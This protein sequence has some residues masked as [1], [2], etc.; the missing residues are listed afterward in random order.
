MSNS[1]AGRDDDAGFSH[2]IDQW[3]EDRLRS[4]QRS[5]GALVSS[6]PGVDPGLA[7]LSLERLAGGNLPERQAAIAALKD[8]AAAPPT[9]VKTVDRPVP[10]P[11]DYFWGY[12]NDS[13]GS[14]IDHVTRATSPGDRVVYLGAPN[15]F[16]ACADAMP[17]RAHFLL[18]RRDLARLAA[19]SSNREFRRV[20]LLVDDVPRLGAQAAVADPPWYPGEMCAF[21]WTAREVAEAGATIWTSAPPAGTRPKVDREVDSVIEWAERGGLE[22]AERMPEG[23]RYRSPPFELASHRAADLGGVPIEWRSGELL[24][25]DLTSSNGI[26]RPTVV[27]DELRWRSLEINEVPICVKRDAA[28]PAEIGEDL[29]GS[30]VGGD[31]LRSVSRRSQ[32]RQ[33]VRVWTSLNRVWS[34]SH[35]AAVGAIC[36]SLR[37]GSLL[38]ES[39]EAAL[40]RRLGPS[41]LEH[42]RQAADHLG[43]IVRLEREEHGI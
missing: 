20:D 28:P 39:V 4:G 8:C 13:I 7:R 31:I 42:V 10:H 38:S 41:E 6:L 3:V 9:W 40:C 1:G 26:E 27:A 23:I 21:L 11:L 33:E 16:D 30:V 36:E 19:G 29:L 12:G 32:I 2:Q 35:P 24:R 18:D 22:L 37:S 14:I 5:F 25:F 43:Y 17:D 34:S 15:A